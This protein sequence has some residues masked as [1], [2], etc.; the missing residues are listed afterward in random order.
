MLA[1]G[2][3]RILV[4]LVGKEVT[5]SSYHLVAQETIGR[6]TCYTTPAE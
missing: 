5:T 4:Y 3:N 2:N 6:A 1:E